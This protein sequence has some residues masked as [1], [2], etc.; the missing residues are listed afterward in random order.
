MSCLLQL[1]HCALVLSCPRGE[2]RLDFVLMIVAVVSSVAMA[3]VF[4]P[5]LVRVFRY[6]T[7]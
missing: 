5:H 4:C 6:S 2:I 1:S 7:V 3:S